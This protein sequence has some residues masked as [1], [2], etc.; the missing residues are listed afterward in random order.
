MPIQVTRL[1]DWVTNHVGDFDRNTWICIGI[2]LIATGFV[3][4]RGF[5]SRTNY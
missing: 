5:G 1:I 4:L 3:T 2:G